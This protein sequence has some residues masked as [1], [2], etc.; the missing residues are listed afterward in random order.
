[1]ATIS[2]IDQLTAQ[3]E[4]LAERIERRRQDLAES[5]EDTRES[6]A[7]SLHHDSD[8]LRKVE[9]TLNELRTSTA[10]NMC[11]VCHKK[12]PEE[13]LLAIPTATTCVKCQKE[14][15][16]TQNPLDRNAEIIQAWK[17]VTSEIE[18]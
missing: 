9:N 3:R 6:L 18:E 2:R 10:Q 17:R 5:D 11:D 8:V 12:I 14:I 13:R 1:M 4:E 7:L 15:D 16:G